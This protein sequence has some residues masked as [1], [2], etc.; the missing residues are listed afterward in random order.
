MA[1]GMDGKSDAELL[2][3]SVARRSGFSPNNGFDASFWLQKEFVC[4]L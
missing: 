1:S 4:D 2:G 3:L